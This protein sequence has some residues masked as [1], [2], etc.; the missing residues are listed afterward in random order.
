MNFWTKAPKVGPSG[1]DWT[2]G[3]PRTYIPVLNLGVTANSPA[4]GKL[5]GTDQVNGVQRV[6]FI[7]RGKKTQGTSARKP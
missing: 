1:T 4:A 2:P 6:S 7:A 3:E 5:G